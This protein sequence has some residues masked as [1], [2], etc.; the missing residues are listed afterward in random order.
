MAEARILLEAAAD[1]A[2]TEQLYASALRAENNLATV[3]E[4]SEHYAEALELFERA[5]ALARRRGDRRW[6]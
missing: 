5:I 1:R 2:H 6:E 3:L 4:G